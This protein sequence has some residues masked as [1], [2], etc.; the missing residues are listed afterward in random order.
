MVDKKE[1]KKD[2]KKKKKEVVASDH[3]PEVK[4]GL[5]IQGRD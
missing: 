3:N 2:V 5:D 1:V 4:I